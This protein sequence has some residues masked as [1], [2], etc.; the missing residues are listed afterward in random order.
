MPSLIFTSSLLS[1]SARIRAGSS[2][3]KKVPNLLSRT[4]S[5]LSTSFLS[6]VAVSGF[7][8]VRYR[9]NIDATIPAAAPFRLPPGAPVARR[10]RPRWRIV[11]SG[12]RHRR[13]APAGLAGVPVHVKGARACCPPFA[14]CPSSWNGR[15]RSCPS[16]PSVGRATNNSRRGTS[17]ASSASV[18]NGNP[19]RPRDHRPALSSSVG[20][21][22]RPLAID[23]GRA[24]PLRQ[25]APLRGWHRSGSGG[26]SFLRRRGLADSPVCPGVR[27]SLVSEDTPPPR[28]R[29]RYRCPIK[30]SR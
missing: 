25:L 11:A 13:P 7:L 15:P 17:A 2:R 8:I 27:V 24:G 10:R 23:G 6:S 3:V 4:P 16:W 21:G 28:T 1:R 22:G 20:H 19:S 18:R 29:R 26:P 5:L 30:P 14:S 9:S 12:R